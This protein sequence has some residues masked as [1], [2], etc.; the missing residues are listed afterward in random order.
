M[1]RLK[2]AALM[3]ATGNTEEVR[4]IATEMTKR[5]GDYPAGW[6]LLAEVALKEKKY[7]EALSLLENVFGR[8]PDHIDGRRVQSNVL[9]AKGDTKKAVEVLERLDQSYPN[10]PLLKDDLGRAWG[11]HE[12][13]KLNQAKL[14]LEGAVSINPIYTDAVVLL[15]Q[16]NL[17]SGQADRAIEPLTDL[18][19]RRP[20][21]KN[22]T[23]LLAAAYGAVDRS[24]DAAAVLESQAKLSPNDPDLA[25]ALGLTYRQAKKNEEAR[26]AFERA[27]QLA[28][29]HLWPIDQLIELDLQDKLYDAARQRIRS[30]FQQNPNVAAAHYFEGKILAA[31]TKSGCR[32]AG[33][34]TGARARS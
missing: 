28:P 17:R 22:A 13:G 14:A 25:I 21:L 6:T 16:V 11:R 26:R 27:A 30:H 32:G 12:S 15:A 20:E 7:D 5:A 31:E 10:V 3:S 9:L 34:A 1:E 23:L 2:Y 29:N 33:A 4:R 19:K 8:D 24:D 18:L